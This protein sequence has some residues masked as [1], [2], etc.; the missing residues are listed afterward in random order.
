MRDCGIGLAPVQYLSYIITMGGLWALSYMY[1]CLDLVEGGFLDLDA[2]S[3]K[4]ENTLDVIYDLVSPFLVLLLGCLYLCTCLC[5][6]IIL[7]VSTVNNMG[8]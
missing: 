2:T 4:R 1:F 6:Y 5:V 7:C 3:H 8:S